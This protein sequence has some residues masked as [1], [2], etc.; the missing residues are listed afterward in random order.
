MSEY[1]CSKKHFSEVSACGK[2]YEELEAKVK[3]LTEKIAY[4]ENREMEIE[5]RFYIL[6]SQYAEAVELIRNYVNEVENPTGYGKIKPTFDDLK[7][8]LSSPAT[9]QAIEIRELEQKLINHLLK[10]K[11]DGAIFTSDI[12][13][14]LS[15]LEEKRKE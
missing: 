5:S 10:R 15:A 12:F 7:N 8:F 3:E 2:C 4:K 6:Q 1:L 14:L 9:K 11:N 13:E